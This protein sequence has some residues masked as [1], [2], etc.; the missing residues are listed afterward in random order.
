[1]F[2]HTERAR[3]TLAGLEACLHPETR[4]ILNSLL[5]Q[6]PD[7]DTALHYLER[8]LSV[9]GTTAVEDGSGL[10]LRG[11]RL[12]ALLAVFA[13]SHFLSDTLLH[14]PGL[15]EWVLG[16]AD[17]YR[18]LPTDEMR[19]GLGPF[20]SGGTDRNAV[21]LEL[22]RFRRQ[23]LLRIML[24]DVLGVATLAE[25]A[26]ELSNLADAILDAA[27]EWV[28]Q[29][30]V[31]WHGPPVLSGPESGRECEFAVIALGK[32]GGE[33]LNYSSDIDLLYLFTGAGETSGAKP[34]TNKEFYIKVANQLTDLLSANTTA[35][36][37]YR[38]DLRLRPEGSLGEV[39]LSLAGAQD[40]Y[41][42]RARDWELQMLIKARAAAGSRD[43]GAGFLD[44]VEPLIYKTTT[45]F[46]AVESVS[47]TR[48]RIHEKLRRRG[49]AGINVKLHHG[50]IRDIEFLV[51]C[52][53]RL[54]G[55]RDPWVRHGGT[56]FAL[57]RLRDKGYLI[58]RDY[59]Q[60]HSAY[61]FLR[62][63][64]HRLQLEND[65]QTH[66]L[67]QDEDALETLAR[68]L[69]FGT[70]S[71]GEAPSEALLQHTA[72]HFQ[73]VTEIYERVIHGHGPAAA[74]GTEAAPLFQLEMEST[75]PAAELS[76]QAQLRY[77]EMRAPE[78]AAH[79]AAAPLHRG[80]RLFEH[81]WGK[82]L[83]M[84]DLLAELEAQPELAELAADLF[85]H[86]PY[87][88]D[89]LIR[90]PE[91]VHELLKV[92]AFPGP[93]QQPALF[94]LEA[95]GGPREHPELERLL[96]AEEPAA[97][98]AAW[99]RRFYRRQMLRI[100]AESVCR[101]NPIFATLEQTTELGDWVVAAA[102]RIALEETL[103][104]HPETS[105]ERVER[106]PMHVVALGRLGMREF[107]LGSDA[108]LLFIIPD[109]AVPETTFWTG[110]A[111]RAIDILASY[112]GEGLLFAVDTRLRP[113]GREGELVQTEG[114]YK[115][116][117]AEEAQAWEAITYMKSRCVAGDI[118][119]ST[120]FLTELQSVDW[121]RYGQSG[122]LGA[123]LLG[124]RRKL[125]KE[126]GAAQPLKAGVGG[127]FDIDFMLMY[128][129]LRGA[130]IFYKSLNTPERIEVIERMGLLA[131]GD[132]DF[133]RTAAVFYRSLD[134]AQRVLTGHSQGTLPRA[135]SQV[136][137]LTEL[138]RRWTPAS[139][140]GR[141]LEA[142][143]IETR[144]RTRQMFEKIFEGSK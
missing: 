39:A 27:L 51:Q 10:L 121:R 88:A 108:D 129:R 44:F 43:L 89:W 119:G 17:L 123:L 56:L 90:N 2:R 47:E 74:Q 135:P 34:L 20:S 76:M 59:A 85:E 97:V 93:D 49:P 61:Q 25:V 92:A 63:L 38:V 33:E 21:T 58:A 7:P 126:Q 111:E 96:R 80:R 115:K 48:E 24:R 103:R 124:M 32:L 40:Y 62:T 64:E 46:S 41:Q 6:S 12:H 91:E 72:R 132:A 95:P 106:S 77:L 87:F 71:G 67:P 141:P 82:V 131:R 65:R 94:D 137:I 117:L 42:R 16:E 81:F 11:S 18:V 138:V 35:G 105:R 3:R 98:K 57:H 52:L 5:A 100:Q 107:D 26:L 15:L 101:R 69:G 127:Y 122:E 110:V 19:A 136:E 31:A 36:P 128:L 143:V 8:Y 75:A 73:E 83:L 30:V 134:H 4:G 29:E 1:M 130:G 86:S 54:Y 102:Y 60:L 104:A 9:A 70:G 50:G 55:G 79:I 78:L 99:L 118:E 53:Q 142:L 28:Y 113:M 66:T 144:Q 139:L 45:D 120:A 140:H 23:H 114:R 84:P 133:L 22:A 109:T 68:K 13:Y 37:C 14:R 112:T 116:Y 125:E